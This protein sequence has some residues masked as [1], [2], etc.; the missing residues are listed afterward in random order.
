MQT[1][2]LHFESF[3]RSHFDSQIDFLRQSVHASKEFD[4]WSRLVRLPAHM[5]QIA[6]NKN[7]SWTCPRRANAK[8]KQRTYGWPNFQDAKLLLLIGPSKIRSVHTHVK[9]QFSVFVD[10]VTPQ[11]SPFWWICSVCRYYHTSSW[12]ILVN[13]LCLSIVPHL[14]LV[15]WAD[16]W[17]S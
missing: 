17:C 15:I 7:P 1:F 11:A 9:W 8:L 4:Q 13:F 3:R 14:K 16:F 2:F 10:S 5:T 12:P 6:T